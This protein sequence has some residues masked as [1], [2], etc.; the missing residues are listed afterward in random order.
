MA[1][2]IYKIVR[3]DHYSYT[4]YDKNTTVFRSMAYKDDTSF[5]IC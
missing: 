3:N 2:R 1:N 5:A 4:V